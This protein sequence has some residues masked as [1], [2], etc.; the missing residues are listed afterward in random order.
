M[1]DMSEN[2]FVGIGRNWEGDVG[3]RFSVFF[4]SS[5]SSYHQLF[6]MILGYFHVTY[7]DV[8]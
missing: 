4:S 8:G 3:I 7:I 1:C 6:R 5:S 2:V